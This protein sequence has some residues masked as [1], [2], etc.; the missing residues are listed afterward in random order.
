MHLA[1][2]SSLWKQCFGF[3]RHVQTC[4][5]VRSRILWSNSWQ[6]LRF[7]YC[8]SQIGIIHVL[9]T[10]PI[11]TFLHSV[12]FAFVIIWNMPQEYSIL[13]PSI[14]WKPHTV[15]VYSL[16]MTAGR[17]TKSQFL[18]LFMLFRLQHGSAFPGWLKF[19]TKIL[20]NYVLVKMKNVLWE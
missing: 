13:R 10:R 4:V 19:L 12:L 17:E 11:Q 15:P 20:E 9:L 5:C 7:H 18:N 1:K 16:R 2:L 3:W 14:K 6:S 8:Q